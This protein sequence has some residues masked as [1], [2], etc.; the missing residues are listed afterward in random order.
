MRPG[1][2]LAAFEPQVP[3]PAGQDRDRRHREEPE[4]IPPPD[5]E[6]DRSEHQE[7]GGE[8]QCAV[9]ATAMRQ[10]IGRI[11]FFE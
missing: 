4:R 11:E 5:R 9:G 10:Q 3:E 2:G 8:M 7:L 6:R 1:G